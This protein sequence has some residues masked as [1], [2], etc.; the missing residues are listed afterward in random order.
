MSLDFQPI[1]KGVF[2]FLGVL[3]LIVSVF[4]FFFGNKKNYPLAFLLLIA[5]IGFF[6][7]IL[8][9]Y[10][11]QNS[12]FLIF[13]AGI[14]EVF[15][16]ALLFFHIKTK[17]TE[18]HIKEVLLHL[19]LPILIYLTYIIKVIFFY[20]SSSSFNINFYLYLTFFLFFYF[21]LYIILSFC[22]YK[23]IVPVV[24]SKVSKTTYWFLFIYIIPH[25][26][27]IV[28]SLLVMIHFDLFPDN[29]FMKDV[30]IN[31]WVKSFGVFISKPL[32]IISCLFI[33]G[34]AFIEIPFFKSFFY[35]KDIL[36]NKRVI[37]AKSDIELKLNNYFNEQ[38]QYK[39]KEL[40]INQCCKELGCSK[41]ELN[42]YLKIHEKATFT[43]YLNY[44]R[45]SEFKLLIQRKENE[46]Y[47]INSIAEMAGF[48][49]RATF[50]RV[51]KEIEG[52]T[53]SEFKNN[54]QL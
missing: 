49:S 54:K 40:T 30:V 37:E 22:E 10:F 24:V 34:Y 52:I 2:L 51:F 28:T 46:I 16:G 5:A 13:V 29:L 6:K 39:N 20:N 47:D 33:I 36:Y 12:F 44:F 11:Y 26:L 45:V 7:G 1:L 43:G 31:M 19:A 48:K 15:I 3:L 42:D 41:K 8:W 9:E 32:T 38:K 35:P 18:L 4:Q 23:K 21:I 17:R 53:P 27:S 14:K 50:Y 25:F